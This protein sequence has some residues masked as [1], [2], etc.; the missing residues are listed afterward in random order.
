MRHALIFFRFLA[1]SARTVVL[2]NGLKETTKMSAGLF[3]QK[4]LFFAHKSI[5]LGTC[6]V[7][8]Y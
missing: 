6:L 5:P 7:V 4:Y 3:M 1:A 2:K 8:Y